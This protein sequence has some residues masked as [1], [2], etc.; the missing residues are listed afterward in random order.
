MRKTCALAVLFF[1]ASAAARAV[2]VDDLMKLSTIVD[3]A[4][5]P[6]GKRVAYAVSTPSLERNAHESAIWISAGGGSPVRIAEGVRV[7]AP[8]LPTPRLRWS[9]DG[10][11][12]SLLG[13]AEDKPQVFAVPLSGG[14]ARPITS[15]PE[16]VAAYEWMPDA[17]GLV[18]LMRDPPTVDEQRRRKDGTFVIHADAP[19]PAT[20][21][22]RQ[23]LDGTPPR[24]LTPTDQYVDSFSISLDGSEVAYSAAP[25]SGFPA[26]Y[27]TRIRIVS[28]AG[29]ETRLV[30]DR[31]GM[32]TSPRFSPDGA[33][34]AFIT[35]NGRAEL[36]AS[37][38]LAVASVRGAA[39][40][41]S[42]PLDDAWSSD[43]IWAAD[44]K[45]IY[46]VNN[47]G[48]FAS[49]KDMFDQPIVRVRVDDGRAERIAA[50]ANFAPSL[51]RDGRRLAFRHVEARTMGDV[52]V[53]DTATGKTEDWSD[54][55]PGL[56][57]L[58]LGDLREVSWRA[59][60]GATIR[61]LLLTP[62][63]RREGERVPLL[64]YCHGGPGGGVTWGIFPQFMQT[65]GQIDF[66]PTE[67]MAS[68][69]YAVFFPMPR[70]G[71]GYGE[72]GQRAIV[73]DWGGIDYRDVMSGVDALVASGVADPDRLGVMGASYGGFLTDWIVT[74]THRFKAASSGE[75]ICDLEDLFLLSDGGEFVAEYFG[76]PWD[77]A[78]AYA[79]HSPI[80]FVQNVTTPLLI[81]HGERDVRTPIAGAWKF[82]RAL[83]MLGKTVELDVYPRATHLYYEPKMER[84]SM[85]RNL[86]WFRRWIP[87]G[88]GR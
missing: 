29:G 83:H 25:T 81:Q 5:S 50:G 38:S 6:D 69:G 56:R 75:S 70:G 51:S 8:R 7:F 4:I 80:R 9:P 46:V 66:Y 54:A 30:V 33:R 19:E 61:G 65:V 31:P 85:T 57:A 72:K 67:A 68:A 79:A 88:T 28:T 13:V 48:T 62:P 36:M 22:W 49:G 2:T 71:A 20:R 76:R 1:I 63:G 60:D 73:G 17:R 74:Q 23:A 18:Y 35:T 47:D 21:L 77:N 44:G 37:R 24:V 26:Q 41:R 10:S 45:S 32:N 84:E 64:V 16:G 43:P 86:E 27:R 59:G 87:A 40:P 12:L 39:Q 78:A 11:R 14:D 3:L 58:S 55:N 52:R 53:L 42:F 34:I 15:A 82:Y